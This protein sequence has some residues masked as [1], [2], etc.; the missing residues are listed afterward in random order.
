MSKDNNVLPEKVSSFRLAETEAAL[1]GILRLEDMQ[2]LQP[3]LHDNKGQV[4]VKMQFGTDEE[5]IRFVRGH[6][7]AEVHLQCQRCMR[8]FV[9]E[10]VDDF[11]SGLVKTEEEAANLPERYDP[12]VTEEGTFSILERVEDELIISLPIVPMHNLKDCEVKS[13]SIL[14]KDGEG[15]DQER[16][17]PFKVIEIL[18]SKNKT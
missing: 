16:E 18:R 1:Q 4:S 13:P 8:P 3:S 10:I 9:F 6:V 15:A 7:E 17:N 5:G 2:R 14:L 11:V 12:V